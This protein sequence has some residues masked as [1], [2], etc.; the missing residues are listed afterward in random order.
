MF[1][2]ALYIGA[3]HDLESYGFVTEKSFAKVLKISQGIT[4]PQ[5]HIVCQFIDIRGCDPVNENIILDFKSSI[6]KMYSREFETFWA[7]SL[8]RFY[9]KE[10]IYHRYYAVFTRLDC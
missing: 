8:A 3:A 7:I 10:H 5:S 6:T 9:D 4:I 2:T 1:S